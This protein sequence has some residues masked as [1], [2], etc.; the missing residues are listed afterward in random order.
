[1][2]DLHSQVGSWECVGLTLN[3]K[4]KEVQAKKH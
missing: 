4:I 1:L 3:E 2:L